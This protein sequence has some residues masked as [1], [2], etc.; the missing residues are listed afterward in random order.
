MFDSNDYATWKLVTIRQP[1][2]NEAVTPFYDI[3]ALRQT[4]TL[5]LRLPRV[6]FFTTP[7][8]LAQWISNLSNQARVTINQTMI[9]A[10]NRAF[11]G[12]TD[13][14]PGMDLSA[15]DAVHAPENGDCYA[16][17]QTL[18]PMRQFF[19]GSY[20]YTFG[21]QTDGNFL[22]V[23]AWFDFGAVSAP[24]TNLAA[25]GELLSTHPDL[26]AAW[27]QKLC[28]YANAFAC[29]AQD[30][31]FKRIAAAFAASGYAWNTLVTQLF[32]SPLV[33]FATPTIAAEPY[34][35]S[36][37]IARRYQLC[38]R[39]S[40]TSGTPDVC[41]LTPDAQLPPALAPLANLAASLPTDV[42][43]RGTVTPPLVTAPNLFYRAALENMCITLAT[44]WVGD[45]LSSIY[46]T[47]DPNQS[48]NLFVSDVMGVPA[49]GA[50][51]LLTMLQAHYTAAWAASGDLTA[52]LQ[53]TFVVA[54]LAPSSMGVG[55]AF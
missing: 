47:R 4:D 35:G 49:S 40:N 29:D 38:A 11:D 12:S 33:T 48:I 54:C 34:A 5:V 15:L 22:G 36:V 24:G 3:D 6:G 55:V 18:D 10:L 21:A 50:A 19:L 9:A 7:A 52:A 17:H 51:P 25:L 16:C 31:E 1:G 2:P 41:G 44:A 42:Y 45:T 46:T 23:P 28:N 8:F 39:L 37:V 26:A 32:A 43:S 30:P 27:T 53:S 20:T 14:T 13:A